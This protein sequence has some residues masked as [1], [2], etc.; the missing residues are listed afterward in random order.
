MGVG[1][2]FVPEPGNLSSLYLPG[3]RVCLC[4][5]NYSYANLFPSVHIYIYN[6]QPVLQV[7]L[8]EPR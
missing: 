7:G 8:F 5:R 4:V 2:K 6:E 1:R 3:G